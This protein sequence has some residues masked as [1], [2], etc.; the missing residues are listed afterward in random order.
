MINLKLVAL[1]LLL[2]ISNAAFSQQAD[3]VIKNGR[4]VDGTGNSW[5]YGDAAITNG[6]IIVTTHANFFKICEEIC[7][8][9]K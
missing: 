2:L 4:I 5:Y 3:I 7:E 8:H 6:K 1:L 9:K